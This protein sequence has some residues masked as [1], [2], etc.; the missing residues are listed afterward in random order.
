MGDRS[1]V[2]AKALQTGNRELRTLGLGTVAEVGGAGVASGPA[3][4][5][6]LNDQQK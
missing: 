2:S 3:G 4:G 1:P 5:A 6:S